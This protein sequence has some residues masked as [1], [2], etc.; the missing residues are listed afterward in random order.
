MQK[1]YLIWLAVFVWMPILLLWAAYPKVLSRYPKTYLH[2]VLGALVVGTAW[3]I[4][5]VKYGI[6]GFPD[7][8]CIA[9][10]GLL[11]W[12]EYFFIIF[13]TIYMVSLTLIL[14]ERFIMH[15]KNRKWN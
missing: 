12:E 2:C 11:P 7:G 6:W 10:P 13:V 5:A 15:K 8:C 9:H 3:D 1:P 4:F 14:R